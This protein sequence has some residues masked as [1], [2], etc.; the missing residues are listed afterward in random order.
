M[1][2]MADQARKKAK[3]DDINSV[4]QHIE[5]LNED[6]EIR[7]KHCGKKFGFLWHTKVERIRSHFGLDAHLKRTSLKLSDCGLH[8]PYDTSAG[9]S[10]EKPILKFTLPKMTDIDIKKSQKILADFFF[11]TGTPFARVE[12]PK[13][14]AFAESLRP[15][16]K[17]VSRK[18]LG[19]KM[20]TDRYGEVKGV[21]SKEL[22]GASGRNKVCFTNLCW[23]YYVSIR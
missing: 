13:L 19:G 11:E 16:F 14:I 17:P 21:V 8:N 15:D 2:N 5:K 12:H 7:C 23:Y 20:L 3:V 22:A 10:N 1:Y 9:S 18:T 6:G 4:W